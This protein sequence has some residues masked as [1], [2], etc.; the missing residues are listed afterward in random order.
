MRSQERIQR[1]R[2]FEDD[3]PLYK[4]NIKFLSVQIF[5]S[6]YFYYI[7][8]EC[9]KV[10]SE[11]YDASTHRSFIIKMENKKT[12]SHE[13][14]KQHQYQKYLTW[15]LLYCMLQW[16]P[17][18]FQSFSLIHSLKLS[19]LPPPKVSLMET[20]TFSSLPFKIS[21]TCIILC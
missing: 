7:A 19:L 5:A 21:V 2:K 11:I 3:E 12:V 1:K 15:S 9:E 13:V 16:G 10:A 4:V 20:Q 17:K 6:G 14:L 8:D 18:I